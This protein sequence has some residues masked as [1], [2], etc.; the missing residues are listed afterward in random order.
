M[1]FR[2]HQQPHGVGHI[3]RAEGRAVGK[4]NA[5]PQMEGD[6]A[7]IARNFPRGRQ[8]RIERLRLTVQPNEHT[9]S[10]VADVLRRFIVHQNRIKSLGFTVE[11]EVQFPTRLCAN[12][13]RESQQGNES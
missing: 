9:T 8:C 10:Q 1:C 6:R 12:R 2:I 4:I 3:L 5:F 13:E 11:A 7:P